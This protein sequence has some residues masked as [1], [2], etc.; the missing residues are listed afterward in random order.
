MPVGGR[1]NGLTCAQGV[2]KRSGN[3]LCLMAVRSDVDVC[4]AYELNHLL[5]ADEAV[6]EDYIRLHSHFLRQSL[7]AGSILVALAAENVWVGRA[8]NQVDNI[9]VPGQDLRQGLNDVF[10]SLVRREQAECQQNRL[11]FHTETILVEIWIEE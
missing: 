5:R 6:M 2:G 4:R 3:H 9:L 8:R 7:Q 10:D 1:N 11:S